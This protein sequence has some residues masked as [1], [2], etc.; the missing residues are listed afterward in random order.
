MLDFFNVGHIKGFDKFKG[1]YNFNQHFI[2]LFFS[3]LSFSINL[4]SR[5]EYN[6]LFVA[7]WVIMVHVYVIFSFILWCCI[8][9]GTWFYFEFLKVCH[10]FIFAFAFEFFLF[11]P[12]QMHHHELYT[13]CVNK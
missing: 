5:F 10:L 6:M 2:F 3:S 11:N 13:S 9:C 7:S 1:F 12:H 4:S 8:Q